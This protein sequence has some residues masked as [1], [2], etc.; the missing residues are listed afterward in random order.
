MFSGAS[1]MADPF[2]MVLYHKTYRYGLGRENSARE[3]SE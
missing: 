2:G 1:G 3:P